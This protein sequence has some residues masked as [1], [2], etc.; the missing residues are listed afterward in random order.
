ML[1]SV[2]YYMSPERIHEHDLGYDFSSDIWSLGCI[3]YE[4]NCFSRM[5]NDELS[6]LSVEVGR[7]SFSV[8]RRKLEPD[9]AASKD[10][11]SRLHAVANEFLFF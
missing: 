6:L 4:V 7:T 5:K 10:R 2:R 1:L 9:F 11:S 3:L 8:L